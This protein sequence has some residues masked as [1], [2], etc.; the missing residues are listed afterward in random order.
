[1]T[2]AVSAV[3]AGPLM[4]LDVA[5]GTSQAVS[6][7][8][9]RGAFFV[10]IGFVMAL[11]IG[12][13]RAALDRELHLAK[14][15][16]ELARHKEAVIQ[17]VSHEF[18]TPLTVISG[19]I[20]LLG[21][22]AV[23]DQEAR[24]LVEGLERATRRLDDLIKVVLAA[25]E[26]LVEPER[27]R[28]ELVVL[29][30]LCEVVAAGSGADGMSRIR[31]EATPDAETVVGDPELI[32]LPL[33]VVVDNALKFSPEKTAVDIQARRL[34]DVVEVL[35]RDRGPGMSEADRRR[36]F[37]PFTQNEDSSTRQKP[38]IGLGLFA[39]RKTIELLGGEIELRPSER[40][41]EA[42]IRLPQGERPGS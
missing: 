25:S 29:R 33:R 11:L 32:A 8:T 3:L 34:G 9:S 26:R 23:V 19:T 10:G 24:E 28:E 36:A 1:M 2:A 12:R 35:V 13:L 6:D 17:T 5:Q 42:V 30:K 18:R 41:T 4:P 21:Q 31:F 20:D 37:E 22:G 15:E 14:A 16:R 40:G 38:G 39:A 27:R 7:W